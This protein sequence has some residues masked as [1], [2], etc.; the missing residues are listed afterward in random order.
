M[1]FREITWL[2]R[3]TKLEER[4]EQLREFVDRG[5]GDNYMEEARMQEGCFATKVCKMQPYPGPGSE[6]LDGSPLLFFK[7]THTLRAT[8]WGSNDKVVK[9]LV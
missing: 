6:R 3:E 1:Y 9:P 8:S 2:G 4:E 7:Y 5:D